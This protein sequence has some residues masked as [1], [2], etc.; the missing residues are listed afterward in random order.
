M[1]IALRM[2][3]VEGGF[4]ERDEQFLGHFQIAPACPH[5]DVRLGETVEI[6]STGDQEVQSLG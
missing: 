1:G 5:L 3:R 6:A 2:M 4:L